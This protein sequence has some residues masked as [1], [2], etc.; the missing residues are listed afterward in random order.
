M[1]EVLV[2]LYLAAGVILM[3]LLA[4]FEGSTVTRAFRRDLRTLRQR[5]SLAVVAGSPLWV[6]AAVFAWPVVA[7]C[8]AI[9]WCERA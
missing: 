7:T 3:V 9:M 8:E 5:G 2:A 6:A 1:V 4:G